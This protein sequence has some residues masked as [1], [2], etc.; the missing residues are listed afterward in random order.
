MIVSKKV[1]FDAAH[2]LPNHDGVCS[3]LHGHHWEVEVAV[4][5]NMNPKTDM[6]MDFKWLKEVLEDI[7]VEPFDHSDLNEAFSNPTAEILARY[8]FSIVMCKWTICVEYIRV[9][10]SK[11]SMVEYNIEDWKSEER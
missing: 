7:V 10:E 11:D 8:I 4:K 1:S 3:K 2:F 6:V 5:G 9:W